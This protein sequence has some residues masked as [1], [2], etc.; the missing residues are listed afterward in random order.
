MGD[1]AV[2][3]F[4]TQHRHLVELLNIAYD[5][6]VEGAPVE[7]LSSLLEDLIEYSTNHFNAEEQSM[8]RNSYPKFAEHLNQHERFT[9]RVTEIYVDFTAGRKHLSLEKLTFVKNWLASHMLFSDAAYGRFV[10]RGLTRR[11]ARC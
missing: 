3:L 6:F 2:S 4:P 1:P 8:K 10:P 7:N 5:N 11:V 9:T